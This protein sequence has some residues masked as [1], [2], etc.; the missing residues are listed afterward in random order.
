MNTVLHAP[1]AEQ[2]VAA[3]PRRRLI[4]RAAPVVRLRRLEEALRT[5]VELYMKREDLLRPLCGNKL[6]YIEFVL[7][8]YDRACAD[9]LIHC[10]G[11]TSNYLAQLAMVGAAEGVPV[12]LVMLGERPPSS[13][14]NVLLSEVFGAKLYFHAGTFG[15]SCSLLKAELAEK[16]RRDGHK[17][18]VVDHPFSNFAATLGYMAGYLELDEQIDR[19]E[20]PAPDHIFLC[21]A[22]NGYLGLRIAD[23]LRGRGTKVTAFPPLRWDEAGLDDVA[24]DRRS[25]LLRKVQQFE[26]FVGTALSTSAIDY[27]DGFVGPGYGV[28][29]AASIEA[30]RQVASIEG[31]LLDP[32]YS[33]KAMAGL[34][35][36][37]KA[38][39]VPA[40]SRVLFVHTGGS[41]NVFTFGESLHGR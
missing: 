30:V 23:D 33:G 2:I 37:I 8:A 11:I 24:N 12:H 3:Q 1:T 41:T 35:A 21:S 9:C 29:S 39:K 25:F 13:H 5:S 20:L 28:P 38:G 40:R 26:H 16:L 4:D 14:A 22:G 19:G 6:R 17:P 27:D 10:G 18:F 15:H 7:G 31:I 32:I 34:L 36:W